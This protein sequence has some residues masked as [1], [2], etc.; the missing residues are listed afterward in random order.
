MLKVFISGYNRKKNNIKCEITEEKE[1][2]QYLSEYD[3]YT[4][5]VKFEDLPYL[6]RKLIYLL[7][8]KSLSE[9]VKQSIFKILNVVKES[10]KQKKGIYW[11]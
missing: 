8:K 6:N 10:Q 1:L 4:E 7:N 2:F 9:N 3:M 11:Y 5:V